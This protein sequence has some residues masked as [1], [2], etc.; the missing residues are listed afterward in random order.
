MTTV[1]HDDPGFGAT[2]GAEWIKLR[3]AR[4]P[5]RNLLLG[6]LLGIGLSVLLAAV[7]GATWDDWTAADR[8]E[9]DPVLF[10][11]SGSLFIAIF[12]AAVGVNATTSEY[13]TGMVRLTFTVTPNRRRVLLAKAAVVTIATGLAGLVAMVGMLAAGQAIFAAND[14]PTAGLGDG[15][16]VRTVVTTA[17]IGPMFPVIGAALGAIMRGTAA[18]LSTVLA[19]IFA[20]SIFGGLLPAWWQR[21]II[22]LLPGPAS[23]S[24]AIGHLDDSEMYPEPIVAAIAVVVWTAGLLALAALLQDRRDA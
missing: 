21:N 18:A 20:P 15:D 5:R 7:V 2:F 1:R 12:F 4:T 23:D 9:F 10:P 11:L 22:S 6:V 8:A 3:T 14:L 17:V 24:L 16:L 19:L 13:A